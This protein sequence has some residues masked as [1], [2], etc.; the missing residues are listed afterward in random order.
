MLDRPPSLDEMRERLDFAHEEAQELIAES[1]RLILE[2][3]EGLDRLRRDRQREEDEEDRSPQ[4]AA[5]FI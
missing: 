1:K 2:S 4:L 3:R 5:P